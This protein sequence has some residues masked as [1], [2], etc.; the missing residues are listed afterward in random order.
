MKAIQLI[1]HG[2]PAASCSCVEVSEPAP[3]A[4]G[5]IAV[6]IQAAAINPADLL[7]FEGRYPG[8]AELPAFV[9]IEGAGVVTAVG[10]GVTEFNIGDHVIS[11][12]RANW[13]EK[14]TADVNQ[15][16]PIPK[17]LPWEQAAQL[18]ANPPSAHLMLTDY[19]DLVPGDWIIQN[20]AN[21]AVGR[22]VIAF[23]KARG[24]HSINIVRR[25][26]LV[27]ELTSLGA[28]L[29]V[30]DSDD[31]AMIVREKTG[32][33]ANIPLGI[34]AIGGTGTLKIADCLSNGGK[35]VNYGFLSGDPCQMTPTHTIVQGLSL[36]GFWLVGFMQGSTRE[37][38]NALYKTM[39]QAFIDGELNV[40][41]EAEYSL[42]QISEALAHAHK[43]GRSGK[44]LLRPNN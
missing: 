15:F 6:E 28:D 42:D 8:P 27:D 14:V 20:A 22:H 23:C 34:D 9:G 29:V 16:V 17:E 26:S 32:G 33:D 44:I 19:V 36:H 1:A 18:K 5:Q 13:S 24:I 25:E 21:S 3:P 39:S 10:D 38:K 43:E 2:T 30:E 41:V 12:G 40:P 4:A 7:I 31:I 35:V 11:M 37:Q